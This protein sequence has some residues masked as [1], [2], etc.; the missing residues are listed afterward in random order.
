MKSSNVQK[1][2]GFRRGEKIKSVGRNS[3]AVEKI[4]IRRIDVTRKREWY[5][6][7]WIGTRRSIGGK[8]RRPII[9]NRMQSHRRAYGKSGDGVDGSGEMSG[10]PSPD[11]NVGIEAAAGIPSPASRMREARKS[12][13]EG[14]A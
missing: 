13:E 2:D 6:L 11:S 14:A 5:S 9:E 3:S 8:S 10:E 7:G 12:S 1:I 4:G